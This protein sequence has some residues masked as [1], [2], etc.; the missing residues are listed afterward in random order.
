MTQKTLPLRG[1]V[2]GELLGTFLLVFF[3]LGSV[4]VAVLT[5]DLVGIG[6]VAAV[7]GLAVSLAIYACASMS[8]AH[9]NPAVTLAF[10]SLRDFQMR[11]VVPYIV[12]QTTGAFVAAALLHV[13]FSGMI[14]AYHAEHAI[15]MQSAGGAATAMLYGEYFPNPVGDPAWTERWDELSTGGAFLAEMLGTALLVGMIF[16]LTDPRNKMAP[17]PAGVPVAIGIALAAIICLIA[18]LTQAGLNPA[19]D[20][21]PRVFAYFAG[22]GPTALPGPRGGF[23][24][25]LLAPVVGGLLGGVLWDRVFRPAPVRE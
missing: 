8:G 11:R 10:A 4:H 23:W 25:Y 3:G 5:G 15:D 19:R 22:W 17:G 1:A 9:L 18:P 24:V 6:Q 12:A 2:L 14:Q 13:M 7:W 21:G 16:A 20:F